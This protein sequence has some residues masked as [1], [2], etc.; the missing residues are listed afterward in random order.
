MKRMNLEP[1]KVKDSKEK[2]SKNEIKK[3][4]EARKKK[5]SSKVHTIVEYL[6]ELK[7]KFINE[8]KPLGYNQNLVEEILMNGLQ[9]KEFNLLSEIV[10]KKEK[11]VQEKDQQ[12]MQIRKLDADYTE[13]LPSLVKNN[14][15][16]EEEMKVRP[17]RKDLYIRDK[18]PEKKS[19]EW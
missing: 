13:L 8:V 1:K 3:K 17:D 10:A 7:G 9:A 14:T 2:N 11:E 4:L 19:K 6:S 18:V 16:D 5:N 12:P 15:I